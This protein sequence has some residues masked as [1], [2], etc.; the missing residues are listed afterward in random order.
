MRHSDQP[1]SLSAN[2]SMTETGFESPC[3][4]RSNSRQNLMN[5]SLHDV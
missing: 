3:L 5:A 2:I 4:N 1:F